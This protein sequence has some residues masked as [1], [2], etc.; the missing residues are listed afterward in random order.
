MINLIQSKD[1]A[2]IDA[3]RKNWNNHVTLTTLR[4]Q[5]IA[6]HNE[7]PNRN[8]WEV[9]NLSFDLPKYTWNWENVATLGQ[10]ILDVRGTSFQRKS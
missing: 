4:W 6:D 5:L 10:K 8:Y 9:I 3:D 7:W 1:C 2:I